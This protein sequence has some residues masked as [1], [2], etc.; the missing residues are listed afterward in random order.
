M[1]RAGRSVLVLVAVAAVAGAGFAAFEHVEREGKAKD[2]GRPCGAL[3]T[4]S[5]TTA[6][7]AGLAFD[8][9]PGATVLRV[10]TQGKTVLVTT[11]VKGDRGDLVHLRDQALRDLAAQGYSA[12]GTDQEPT[13]EAEGQFGGRLE[14]SVKVQPLCQG[15][16]SVRYTFHR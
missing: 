14:G 15:H 16:D 3:T 8:V 2:A 4:P 13:Y 5:G 1:G 9:P 12:K 6:L 11:S 10:V 7:P